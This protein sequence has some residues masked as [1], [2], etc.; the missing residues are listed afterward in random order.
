M[1]TPA[2]TPIPAG[3]HTL[4]AHIICEGAAD[5]IAFYKKAFHA[6][7]LARLPGPG[8][9]IMHA[10]VRIG[11]S[12]LMLMDDFAEWG[13]LGP[14]ALKGT[15]V[16]LHLYVK[17]VDAAMKQA[18]DAG[19]TMAMPAEDMFWGDRYGQVVDPFGHRWSIATHQFDYTPE[20]IQQNM[21]KMGE[22]SG[23]GEAAKK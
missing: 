19:A 18:L 21:A 13:S 5:A 8:G 22:M 14:K 16:T 12:V 10:A 3:M 7:E 11:D 2:T 17:D 6:E 20:E 1:A 9:K 4:T 23:C 15:P